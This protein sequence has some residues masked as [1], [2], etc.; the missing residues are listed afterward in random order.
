MN[1]HFGL[2]LK[3]TGE[4]GVGLYKCEGESAIPC[5]DVGDVSPEHRIDGVADQNVAEIV[6]R[7]LVLF[8]VRG[9]QTIA[10]DHIVTF[11]HLRDHGGGGFRGVGV[12]AVG[13]DI[14]IGVDVFEHGSNHV[15]FALAGLLAYHCARIGCDLGGPVRRVV[16]ID[17]HRRIGQSGLKVGDHL[18]DGEFLVVAREQNGCATVLI[19]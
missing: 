14:D 11:E 2:D 10:D 4:H 19:H 6:E 8:E 18:A 5:H 16:V 12:I 1:R 7:A 13:H 17:V 9:A 3:A 15:S